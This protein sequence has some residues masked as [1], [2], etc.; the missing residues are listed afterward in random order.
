MSSSCAAVKLNLI[1][2][3]KKS[4][5]MRG[6][7][8]TFHDCLRS[9]TLDDDCQVLRR[10]FYDCRRAQLDN[11]YRMRGNPAFDVD[12]DGDKLL[13]DEKRKQAQQQALN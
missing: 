12:V 8:T 2:C 9:K 10:A 1:E 5:C 13:E 6:E 3:I 4:E 11:R 7:G